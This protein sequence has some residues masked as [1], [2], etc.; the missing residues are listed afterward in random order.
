[1]TDIRDLGRAALAAARLLLAATA[2]GRAGTTERVSVSSRGVQGNDGFVTIF[3]TVSARG[4]FV[5]F[6]SAATNLVRGD[7]NGKWDVFVRTLVRQ[8]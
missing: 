7:T 4:R 6:S 1:M 2:P 5:A 8:R 3:P